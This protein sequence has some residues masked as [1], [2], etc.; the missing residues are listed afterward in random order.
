MLSNDE[1]LSSF[2]VTLKNRNL[3]EHTITAYS[4]DLTGFFDYCDKQDL[5]LNN[6]EASDLRGFISQRVTEDQLSNT[7]IRRQVAAVRQFM[8]WANLNG[9]VAN[10]NTH[11]V[12]VKTR[13]EY[14]PRVLEIDVV[15]QIL[16]QTA[17]TDPTQLQL[18]IRDKAIMELFYSTGMRLNELYQ[19][20]LSDLDMGRL[21]VKVVGKGDKQRVIPFGTKAKEAIIAWLGVYTTWTGLGLE[22][23]SPLFISLRNSRLSYYQIY[24]RLIFQAKRAGIDSKI[25]PHI[26]RHSFATHMLSE[27]GDLRSVQE[28]L[29][30]A[31]LSTTQIYTHLDFKSI[32]SIYDKAHPR[33]SKS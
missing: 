23:Q 9:H 29:G 11:D 8:Q 22:R 16:D 19:L 21:L 7:S 1:L 6:I 32:A 27:S 2:I 13:S 14:L 4:R 24:N 31:S 25:H 10:N 15:N 20:N 18:W 3:S 30:H 5:S 28:M 26:F 12:S 33:A 17:P